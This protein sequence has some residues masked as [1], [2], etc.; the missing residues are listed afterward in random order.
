LGCGF[1]AC[2]FGNF[3]VC[4][5]AQGGNIVGRRPYTAAKKRSVDG[6]D[7]FEG[8]FERQA[9]NSTC[10]AHASCVNGFCECDFGWDGDGFSC[11]RTDPLFLNGFEIVAGTEDWAV[12]G[13][14]MLPVALE[15][16]ALSSETPNV[17]H[18]MYSEGYT[19]LTSCT[20]SVSIL[21]DYYTSKFDLCLKY[22]DANN[23][24]C[25]RY[26]KVKG[27]VVVV[28]AQNGKK[29]IGEF[30]WKYVWTN[31]D[32]TY[33]QFSVEMYQNVFTVSVGGTRLGAVKITGTSADFDI[34]TFSGGVALST[35][36]VIS[37]SEL[38]SRTKTRL[39]ITLVGCLTEAE[40]KQKI[41]DLLGINPTQ[42]TDLV[43]GNC[44][45]RQGVEIAF[46]IV[47]ENAVT[48][49]MLSADLM[50][51][52]QTSDPALAQNG[53]TAQSITPA[54]DVSSAPADAVEFSVAEGALTAAGLTAGAIAGIAI[55][56]VVF[57]ALAASAA[58][59]GV[60]VFRRRRASRKESH[61]SDDTSDI[62]TTTA[63]EGDKVEMK[64]A[65]SK[66]KGAGPNVYD[67][68]PETITSI[69]ARAPPRK[70]K[71]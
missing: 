10:G 40:F 60:Y 33:T 42:I 46:T 32:D 39:V 66:P 13:E 23:M 48:S 29:T 37:F 11:N 17:V 27:R 65:K 2:S 67:F 70:V 8:L 28:V 26:E 54:P 38:F 12:V 9:C 44:N 56:S 45:K 18:W 50:E 20:V 24:I 62:A 64:A 68:D 16:S 49:Q 41:A 6:E 3:W 35:H 19:A 31:S 71:P 69:T 21:P 7:G 55:G 51:M 63:E 52:V 15:Y 47:G 1:K 58:V 5:Y 61:A 36:G 4:E 14:E 34:S 53:I 30:G 43:V 25:F 22:I 57:A 59:G